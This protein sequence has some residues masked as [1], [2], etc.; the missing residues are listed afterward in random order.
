L[1]VGEPNGN[2]GLGLRVLVL[3]EPSGKVA[4]EV[5]DARFPVGGAEG[6]DDPKRGLTDRV[7]GLRAVGWQVR[8]EG[9]ALGNAC[10]YEL[11]EYLAAERLAGVRGIVAAE[12]S[13]T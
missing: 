11:V 10:E 2:Q 3:C 12:C 1:A 9:V 6:L 4:A 5:A 8:L 13:R 7:V